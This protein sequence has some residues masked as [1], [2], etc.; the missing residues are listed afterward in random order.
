[1]WCINDE[2]FGDTIHVIAAPNET[3][4]FDEHTVMIRITKQTGEYKYVLVDSNDYSKISN[5][6]WYAVKDNN[7]YYAMANIQCSDGVYRM[8]KMHRFLMF[9]DVVTADK[10]IMIDHI[11]RN[12]LDNRRCNL[13]YCDNRQN[14]WNAKI[15]AQNTT[16]VMGVSRLNNKTSNAYSASMRLPDGKRLTKTFS[17][18]KYGDTQAFELAKQ[19]RI[20]WENMYRK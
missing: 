10:T 12:G 15:T 7:T 19:Q 2:L 5:Y 4:M 13:R 11:N 8:V 6:K 1:M 17:V 9:D 18:N 20:T 3:A 16:G 14:Q